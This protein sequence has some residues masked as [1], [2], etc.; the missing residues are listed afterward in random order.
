VSKYASVDEAVK[1]S[2]GLLKATIKYARNKEELQHLLKIN[3]NKKNFEDFSKKLETILISEID[4]KI[5]ENNGV[6]QRMRNI[7][8]P[9]NKVYAYNVNLRNAIQKT[10]I[11][12][13]LP[14]LPN[15]TV[16]ADSKVTPNLFIGGS[17]L[18]EYKDVT[19]KFGQQNKSNNTWNSYIQR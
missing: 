5:K 6:A 2:V 13:G 9:D 16:F 8:Y 14:R 4:N 1:W 19:H 11:D 3:D 7:L 12:L 15:Y 10:L 17:G 18:L